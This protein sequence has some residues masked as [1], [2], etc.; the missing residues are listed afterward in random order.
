MAVYEYTAI[1]AKGKTVKG[2]I[3]AESSRSARQ[4]L[5]DRGIF[6]TTMH[7]GEEQKPN[8]SWNLKIELGSKSIGA[9]GLAILTRRLATLVGAGMTLVDS[10]KAV[11]EQVEKPKLK[12]VVASLADD[13]TEGA[14]FADALRKHPKIF[15]RLY[16]NMVSSAETSGTLD[17]ILERL[18]DLYEAQADLQSKVYTAITYPALMLV[19]CVVAVVVLLTYVVPKIT[20]I[21]ESQGAALPLLTQFVVWLSVVLKTWWWVILA[22]LIIGLVLFR[23]YKATDKGQEKIDE[24][25]LKLP[26]VGGLVQ[27]IA[28]IRFARN[29]GNML[30]GGVEMISALNIAKSITGNRT[31][32]AA[33]ESAAEGVS[34]GRSLS[35]E[36]KKTG[37]FPSVLIHM[38][39]TG[40]NSG[41]LESML[42]K[43]ATSY[44]NEV[45]TFLARLTSTLE[46]ILIIFVA[47]VVGGIILSVMLPMLELSSIAAG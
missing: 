41:Q 3:D 42:L 20:A 11:A 35:S 36:L 44:E 15:P 2:V 32:E 28:T 33:I 14:S 13:V 30:T 27:K 29:L 24:I 16:V 46:P 26:L 21:F 8:S 47:V 18:A 34:E 5:N 9:S 23:R 10:L 1:N 19:L 25:L 22:L 4:K 43:S 40:E 39:N 17:L 31:F 6:P 38:L 12:K 7:E 45:N 37:A